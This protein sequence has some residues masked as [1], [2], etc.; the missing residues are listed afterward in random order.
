MRTPFASIIE[1]RPPFIEISMRTVQRRFFRNFVRVALILLLQCPMPVLHAHEAT[2]AELT[3]IPSL[4]H[5]LQ[6]F[7]RSDECSASGG[8][9]FGWHLHFLP[10]IGTPDG[11]GG[12]G[13]GRPDVELPWGSDGTS[14]SVGARPLHGAVYVIAEPVGILFVPKR[15]PETAS[16]ADVT[17]DEVARGQRQAVLRA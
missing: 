16:N 10:P 4:P 8:E 1:R 5:H 13:E 2:A 9:S 14:E 6:R 7:H 17:F 12:E 3:N 15:F 11:E